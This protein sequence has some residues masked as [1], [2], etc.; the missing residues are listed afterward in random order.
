[1]MSRRLGH[2]IEFSREHGSPIRGIMY[3]LASCLTFAEASDAL[4]SLIEA[5]AITRRPVLVRL[6]QLADKSVT[7]N[8]IDI[9]LRRLILLSKKRPSLRVRV[10]AVLSQLWPHATLKMKRKII[11][12]WKTDT[13]LDS[14]KRWLRAAA[15]D[16]RFFNAKEIL[17]YWRNSGNSRAAQVIAYN[18]SPAFLN[19]VLAE[20][21]E[22]CD[23][24]WIVGRAA[25]RAGRF[26][27]G[28]FYRLKQRLPATYA[29][30]CAKTKTPITHREAVALAAN[31]RDSDDRSLILWSI[32]QLGIWTALEEIYKLGPDIAMRDRE[33]LLER[34]G[35]KPD[36][37]AARGSPDK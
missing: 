30:V 15:D 20:L 1:M 37:Q 33:S 34:H 21:L 24:G 5:D 17:R 22:N 26:P 19:G 3:A 6:L 18:A 11:E 32:G 36:D 10:N 8:Q 27:P 23:E 29:Y 2:F 12:T 35:I 13:L 28:F 31:E 7:A 4:F 16:K 9:L 25:I 14:K